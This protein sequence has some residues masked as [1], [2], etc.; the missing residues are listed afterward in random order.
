MSLFKLKESMGVVGKEMREVANWI[1]DNVGNPTIPMAE[2]NA[3]KARRDE[4]QARFD[5]LKEEHDRLEKTERDD[6]AKAAVKQQ[7][8]VSN[9]PK[10]AK[11]EAKG[12]FYQAALLGG[13]QDAY[14]VAQNA[15]QHLGAIPE[16][17]ADLGYGDNLLPTTMG[18]ELI[19][20][21]IIEN[22]MR[23]IVRVSNITGLEEPKLLFDLDDA[24]DNVTDKQ[25]AKEIEMK[26]DKV[27]YG[28]NKVKVKA[29]V[30]D[31]VIHGSPINLATEIENALRSGLAANE[32]LRM[33]APTPA[34]GYAEMSFYSAANAV[35]V[36]TGV[37]KQ[38][39]IA[40]ALADLPIFFRRNAKIVMSAIDWYDMWKDNLN[41]SGT[42]Y[43]ERPLQLFGK[44]VV[45]VDDAI[46]PVVGD[47]GYCRINYDIGTIYDT[48]KDIDSGIYKFV[49]TAWYDIK[50]R[51]ASA[52]RIVKSADPDTK[53]L[54]AKPAA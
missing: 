22:P 29:K 4:L 27:A 19:V 23:E 26:G 31:T 35:K 8:Q 25:T 14:K 13:P 32:M 40:A 15:Y 52:F 30:S 21:P 51:L 16:G 20:E 1:A 34:A 28:R 24:F 11:A 17:N 18:N 47:F 42:F 2:V 5:L 46:D 12:Q 9:D 36:V 7:K 43:E 54:K 50:L 3:K 41:K 48:D 45:L 33:F 49:L 44:K 39:A 53:Q 38:A 10:I 37:T 6:A